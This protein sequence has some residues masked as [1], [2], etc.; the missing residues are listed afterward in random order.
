MSKR[1]KGEA[2]KIA[3]FPAAIFP[4]KDGLRWSRFSSGKDVVKA[5]LLYKTYTCRCTKRT[6]QNYF[7]K[8]LNEQKTNRRKTLKKGFTLY[9]ICDIIYM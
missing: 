4:S 5:I 8:N 6:L 9:I 1:T 2:K 3:V 7:V